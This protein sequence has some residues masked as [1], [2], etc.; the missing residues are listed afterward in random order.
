MTMSRRVN[1][2]VRTSGMVARIAMAQKCPIDMWV[3]ATITTCNSTQPPNALG[4]IYADGDCHSIDVKD[5]EP[6]DDIDLF[7][8]NYRAVCTSEG[9]IRFLDSGCANE[10]CTSTSL[11]S[12]VSTCDRNNSLTASLYARLDPPE[13]PLL[14]KELAST[15]GYYT[16]SRL[17]GWEEITVSFVL[18][19]DCSREDCQVDRTFN[20]SAPTSSAALT[21][22]PTAGIPTHTTF[23]PTTGGSRIPVD[24]NARQRTTSPKAPVSTPTTKKANTTPTIAPTARLP[25]DTDVVPSLPLPASTPVAIP[26]STLQVNK[27][28]T[29]NAVMRLS[30]MSREFDARSLSLWETITKQHITDSADGAGLGITIL[31]FT[32]ADIKQSVGNS[33]IVTRRQLQQG[34]L[35]LE[36]GITMRYSL[37]KNRRAPSL[38]DIV[39][40]AFDSELERF[41]YLRRFG[42]TQPFNLV[43]TVSVSMDGISATTE[44][45]PSSVVSRKLDWAGIVIGVFVPVSVAMGLFVA[46]RSRK[47]RNTRTEEATLCSTTESSSYLQRQHQ[48]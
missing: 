19:G 11:Y 27:R 7:P 2:I 45:K 35:L 46:Y 9:R 3:F 41:K 10:T 33:T 6:T 5:S 4:T 28:A 30:P 13:Y 25:S 43:D 24:P 22:T 47:R 48:T 44:G 23:E 8:G 42:S 37:M 17:Q 34:T 1:A 15:V 21:S 32:F 39:I 36:F 26:T 18:F 20:V 29:S 14:D 40:D 16:C 38:A 31:E 12:D